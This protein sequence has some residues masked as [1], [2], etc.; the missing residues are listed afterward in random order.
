MKPEAVRALLEAVR[1]GSTGVD[2]ALRGLAS[3][4]FRELEHATVDHHRAVRQGFPEVVYGEGK[5]A[6]QIVAIADA[7]DAAGQ[8]VLVTRVSPDKAEAVRGERPML[9]H[10]AL[11]RTLRSAR[12]AVP[13]HP[14]RVAIVTAG[15]SDLPAA[16]EAAETLALL[17]FEPARLT[18]VGV[19]GLHRLLAKLDELR[20]AEAIIVCAGME[21]ALPSV[22]GGLVGRAVI[23]V[24]TSVGYGTSA[25]GYAALLTM[26][27]SCASGIVVCNI[28][29][30]FGAAM[31]VH[32][33][34]G[35]APREHEGRS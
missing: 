30:G 29:A 1:E 21:G 18:D 24:P 26:L 22:I 32:R 17:G 8:N 33:M 34:L 28:D 5:S 31:A 6:S 25:G 27:S 12:H 20:A 13:R 4:P 23:A 7:I 35:P 3:L 19:A 11:G 2:E 16:E 14:G 10:N 9:A 15:T